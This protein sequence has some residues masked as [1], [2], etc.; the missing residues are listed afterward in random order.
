[1]IHIKGA[2]QY[3]LLTLSLVI[4]FTTSLV[5]QK[6]SSKVKAVEA[7]S[8]D[9]NTYFKPLLWRNIGPNRGG[10]SV[11]SSGVKGNPLVYYMGSTGGGVWKTEDAGQSWK[12]I[13]DGSFN[14][15]SVGSVAVSESDP[16]VIYVGMGEHA[17]RG[18][19]TSYGD[20]IYKSTNGGKTWK[21]LGLEL[22]RHIANIRIH[23]NN[24][25]VVY[26]AAQG[27]LNGPTEERGIYKS[28]D[29]GATWKKILY[30]DENTGCVDLNMDMNNPRVL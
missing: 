7:T 24:P 22:S 27:A 19:M 17:P 20:G 14:T 9:L 30:V 2:K 1:M 15:G 11:T 6:K 8:V 10:R 29:G 25:D 3:M 26:V 21:H 5:A 23:P 4:F 13:S 16:N 28:V 18:V 12:N